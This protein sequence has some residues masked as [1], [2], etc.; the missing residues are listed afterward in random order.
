MRRTQMIAGAGDPVAGDEP[1]I[2]VQDAI[3]DTLIGVVV[4]DRK[5]DLEVHLRNVVRRRTSNRVKRA[6][7]Q[8]RVSLEVFADED[9]PAIAEAV[10]GHG[11]LVRVDASLERAQVVHQLCSALRVR[12]IGD[13]PISS[14]LDAYEAGVFTPRGVMELTGLSRAEF[15]NA[16]RRL[17]RMLVTVPRELRSAALEVMRET[18]A[19]ARDASIVSHG[20]RTRGRG[21]RAALDPRRL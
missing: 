7:K 16:R 15:L 14:I 13:A 20:S 19:L 21:H 3:T 2:L 9:G 6:R 5:L 1:S 10:D 12:A 11:S 17:D 4:W 8:V 18:P